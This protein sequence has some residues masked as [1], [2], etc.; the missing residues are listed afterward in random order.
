MTCLERPAEKQL[1][2]RKAI[3]ANTKILL[4]RSRRA[5]VAP[6]PSDG[7]APCADWKYRR[8]CKVRW[9]GLGEH[10]HP[11]G[12]RAGTRAVGIS[13]LWITVCSPALR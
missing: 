5:K 12:A 2:P 6:S 10:V 13:V 11:G 4:E 8:A 9:I 1:P 7:D 3:S